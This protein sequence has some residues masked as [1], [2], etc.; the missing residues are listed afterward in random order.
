VKKALLAEGLLLSSCYNR[1]NL[2][3]TDNIR[4]WL[5]AENPSISLGWEKLAGYPQ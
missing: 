4:T 5:R 2:G 3:E 1:S